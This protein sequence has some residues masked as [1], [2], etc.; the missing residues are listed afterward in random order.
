MLFSSHDGVRVAAAFWGEHCLE[1]GAPACYD[2]C[3]RFECG[4]SGRCRLF[5]NGMVPVRM[6]NGERGYEIL[7]K[8]WAKLELKYDGRMISAW[9]ARLLSCINRIVSPVMALTNRLVWGRVTRKRKNLIAL[10]RYVMERLVF[11][12]GVQGCP[13]R[14]TIKCAASGETDLTVSIMTDQAGEVLVRKLHLEKG[15]NSFE[16]AVPRFVGTAYFRIFSID[17]TDSPVTF[18]EL[19]VAETGSNQEIKNHVERSQST[20]PAKYVKCV[21]W[22]LD[23][24][25]WDGILVEDGEDGIR[26]RQPVMDVIRELD[27]R[28][29]VSSVCSKNDADMA[30]ACL[31]KLGIADYFVFPMINWNPK[32]SNLRQLSKEMNI[33]LNAI[34]FVD[35]SAHE[36][37]EVSEHL[38]MV[39]VF[40][41]MDAE[42]LLKLDCFNPPA[43]MES[44]KRRMSYL[45][46]MERRKNESTFWGS[47]DEFLRS[48]EI[49]LV[50]GTVDDADVR[51]RCWELVNRTNQLTLAGK[52]YEE[53]EFEQ[54]LTQ[55]ESFA[56]RCK[57]KYGDY[58]I[59]GFAGV[60][61][62][63][64]AMFVRE[65]VMSC[66]VAKKRCEAAFVNWLANLAHTRKLDRI[67]ANVVQTGRNDALITAF[68]EISGMY[69]ERHETGVR[70]VMNLIGFKDDKT[71]PVKVYGPDGGLLV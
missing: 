14:W 66:R 20:A 59:V 49:Q 28:G 26:L 18:T 64:N 46:E 53:G 50:C 71:L 43:S 5:K 68:D 35:D 55:C 17:G 54:F 48:C 60:M 27:R 8:A 33:G 36:R 7:F 41:E 42:N 22:D 69:K 15:D 51:K 13:N 47:H 1:C 25:L 38:P 57:D 52:R 62:E 31:K 3:E 67:C 23:N 12:M 34:A 9:V 70:Y 40:R 30:L 45:V 58:G 61:V 65:F 39:R 4:P 63:S 11:R 19:S 6:P 29:I 2:S 16:F 21:A 24:T 32:S 10:W 56:I 44:G 37:G